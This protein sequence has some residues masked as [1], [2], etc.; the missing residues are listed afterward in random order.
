MQTCLLDE[1]D[2]EILRTEFIRIYRQDCIRAINCLY[3][4]K[5][6]LP[7]TEIVPYHLLDCAYTIELLE[8]YFSVPT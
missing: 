4:L 3:E 7:Q 6:V 2:K 8:Q 5:S 1:E